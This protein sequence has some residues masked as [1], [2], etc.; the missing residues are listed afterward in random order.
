MLSL[1]NLTI[2]RNRNK[3]ETPW[4]NESSRRQQTPSDDPVSPLTPATFRR[5]SPDIVSAGDGSLEAPEE[6]F[7]HPFV[8]E[9]FSPVFETKHE[10]PQQD[11]QP[12]RYDHST[13]F[14]SGLPPE[15]TEEDIRGLLAPFGV[16]KAVSFMTRSTF[17]KP[18]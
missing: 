6:S 5:T 12:V 10:A 11:S 8:E 2:D 3:G 14:V 15:A 13:L 17:P 16:I 9:P 4:F 7:N 18:L 1:L